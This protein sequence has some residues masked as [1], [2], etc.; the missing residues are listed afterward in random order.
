MREAL[1]NRD[2]LIVYKAP[3]TWA[4]IFN[5]NYI[6]QRGEIIVFV[7]KGL[8]ENGD[9]NEKQLIKRV[10]GLPGDRIIIKEGTVTVINTAHPSG[11][12]PDT[13]GDYQPLG[14]TSGEID[15]NVGENEIFVM[16]DNRGNSLDSRSFGP[17]QSDDIVG[18]LTLRILPFNQIKT[19]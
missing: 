15:Y 3:K 5:N 13:T 6:P 9:K 16:G 17:I 10:V 7:K 12:N 18:K 4:R 19:F 8:Y 1:Q 2:R 14:F 11:Y